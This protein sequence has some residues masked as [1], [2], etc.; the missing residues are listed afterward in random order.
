MYLFL[1]L[2]ILITFQG[3]N[4][5]REFISKKGKKMANFQ[6]IRAIGSGLLTKIN[7]KKL[8]SN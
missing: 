2:C 8:K 1:Y 6:K 3:K 4:P 5:T 7:S